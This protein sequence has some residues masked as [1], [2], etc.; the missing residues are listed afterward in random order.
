MRRPLAGRR[1]GFAVAL[2]GPDG[3]GKTTIAR[4]LPGTLSAPAR[5]IYMGVAPE[6]SNMLLPT[7]RLVQVLKRRRR[8]D[9][10]DEG[11]RVP[12]AGAAGPAARR[13][14]A[15]RALAPVRAALAG[16][17]L[18]NR[19]AE[20]WSRQAVASYHQA[21]GTITIF[22]RHFFIDYHAADIAATDRSLRRR[23][24]GWILDRLYPRPDLVIYL[25]APPEVLLARKGEGTLESLARRR[26]DYLAIRHEVPRFDVVDAN[27][28]LETV[29]GEVVAAIEAFAAGWGAAGRHGPSG[30]G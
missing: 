23:L 7:T 28:P 12:V 20:E 25:D 24:H 27:R 14:L 26:D 8:A 10:S 6:S 2:I 19:L 18:A 17:R 13:R 9:R 4:D 5:Y 30:S 22:D 11:S 21:R 1:R 29:R 3:A 16:L 15:R